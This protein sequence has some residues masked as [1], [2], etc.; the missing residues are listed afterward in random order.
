[1]SSLRSSRSTSTGCA[2]CRSARPSGRSRSCCS[3]PSGDASRR[4]ATC[5]GS[6]RAWPASVSASSAGTTAAVGES[7]GTRCSTRAMTRGLYYT[8]TSLDGF[9]AD[10]N[11]SLTWLFEQQTEED[12]PAGYAEFMAGIGAMAMGSTTYVWLR[13]HLAKTGEAWMY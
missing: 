3:S 13:E 2:P 5:G 11:D 4:T 8:A 12:G 6:G 10:E 1:M 9:I 7:V